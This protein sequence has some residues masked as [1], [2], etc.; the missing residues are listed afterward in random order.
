MNLNGVAKQFSEA[1]EC[2]FSDGMTTEER[3]I[4]II[5]RREDFIAKIQRACAAWKRQDATLHITTEGHSIFYPVLKIIAELDGHDD[6]RDMEGIPSSDWYGDEVLEA[7]YRCVSERDATLKREI[8]AH[9]EKHNP[10]AKATAKL[11]MR[12]FE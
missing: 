2:A 11:Q 12:L 10:R 6:I 3:C 1:C 5:G 8:L 7:A 4:M 9:F